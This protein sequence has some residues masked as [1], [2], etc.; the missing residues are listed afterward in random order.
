MSRGEDEEEIVEDRN[1]TATSD[2]SMQGYPLSGGITFT[3]KLK[4]EIDRFKE[5][6]ICFPDL[7]ALIERPWI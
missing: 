4:R 1:G 3:S 5:I 6:H 7:R 2:A